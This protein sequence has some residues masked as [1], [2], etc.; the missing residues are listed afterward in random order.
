[1]DSILSAINEYRI[2]LGAIVLT[3]VA[4]LL[5]RNFWDQVSFF[6]LRTKMNMPIIGKIS[7]LSKQPGRDESG[8]FHAE[9]DL[10]GEFRPYFADVDKSPKFY[11]NCKSY[12]RKVGEL[13][14]KKLGFLERARHVC[15]SV[16]IP[17]T[18]SWQVD[19]EEF[20]NFALEIL[21]YYYDENQIAN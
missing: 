11:D 16:D 21:Q 20:L 14:R 3:I 17:W 15:S 18:W 10:C 12:L 4:A 13:G 2:I 6:W 7:R 9:K 19:Y 8:W 1:M 5:I